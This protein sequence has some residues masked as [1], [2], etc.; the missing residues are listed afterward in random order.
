M[1]QIIATTRFRRELKR[2]KKRGKD[3]QL[4]KD[5]VA[6]LEQ[7]K[8]LPFKNKDRGLSGNWENFRDCHV[9]PDWILVY[10]ISDGWLEL[11]ATGSHSDLGF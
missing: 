9:T 10:R 11:A 3:M 2:M 6:L 8:T 7:E 5:V 1:L 4:L